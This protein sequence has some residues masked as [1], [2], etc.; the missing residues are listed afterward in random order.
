MLDAYKSKTPSIASHWA[1]TVARAWDRGMEHINGI[2]VK[3]LPLLCQGY[4]PS[5]AVH[6][7]CPHLILQIIDVG[8]DRGLGQKGGVCCL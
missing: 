8:A 3:Q 5:C 4:L 7:G 1:C 6:K 2:G